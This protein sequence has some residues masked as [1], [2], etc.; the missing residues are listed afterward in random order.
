MLERGAVGESLPCN[1]GNLGLNEICSICG[2]FQSNKEAAEPPQGDC[3][4]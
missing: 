3:A 1:L 4:G 2:E